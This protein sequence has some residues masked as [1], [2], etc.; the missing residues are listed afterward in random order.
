ME[1]LKDLKKHFRKQYVILLWDGLPAHRSNEMKEFL[2]EHK[3]WLDAERLPGYA[4]DLN[5]VEDLWQ[6]IKSQELANQSA[7]YLSEVIEAAEEGLERVQSDQE[8][9]FGFLH[10]TGHFF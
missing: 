3:D 9:L 8:L 2:A 6:N 1:F 10:H 5:P 4:P 7:D